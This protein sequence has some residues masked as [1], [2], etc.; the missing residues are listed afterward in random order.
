MKLRE[1]LLEKRREEEKEPILTNIREE[2]EKGHTAGHEVFYAHKAA[3]GEED[4]MQIKPGEKMG[5][6]PEGHRY[7]DKIK[8]KPTTEQLDENADWIKAKPFYVDKITEIVG[9]APNG[10]A[11]A[12]ADAE[13]EQA[14]NSEGY[15]S[16]ADYER[17]NPRKA[18]SLREKHKER[19]KRDK[20]S[21]KRADKYFGEA[22]EDFKARRSGM[23]KSL[24][25]RKYAAEQEK[26]NL[27]NRLYEAGFLDVNEKGGLDLR[28]Y[29]AEEYEK[30]K[31][32]AATMGY[33]PVAKDERV[34]SF[35]TP[36]SKEA[37][38]YQV[39]DF[40]KIGTSGG[41]GTQTPQS[42]SK[43]AAIAELKR[44]GKM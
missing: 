41:A 20:D 5:K 42:V 43:E 38:Q 18:K 30:L 29:S 16:M 34:P 21:I 24:A 15:Q 11:Y 39:V 28:T 7:E 14:I 17:Y 3:P 2:A 35:W 9:I 25:E 19:V 26:D 37:R 27:Y 32:T 13:M 4:I 6:L 33:E 31:E 36:E 8:K 22:Q 10:D 40:R 1:S 44:R 12:N 23:D